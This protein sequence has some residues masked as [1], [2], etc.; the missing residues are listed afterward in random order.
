MKT[1]LPGAQTKRRACREGVSPRSQ[2]AELS[3]EDLTGRVCLSNA[4]DYC[5]S[6]RFFFGWSSPACLKLF[7]IG[8]S[9]LMC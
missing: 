9:D 8:Q 3:G 2:A 4:I 5:Y 6:V 1:S 7:S